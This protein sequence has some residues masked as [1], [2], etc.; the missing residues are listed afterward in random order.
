MD[1]EQRLI[2]SF[3]RESEKKIEM[4]AKI[5]EFE[6]YLKVVQPMNAFKMINETLHRC[7][8]GK[9]LRDCI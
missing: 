4:E 1:I 5:A 9:Q 6:K 7:L 2:E 8:K 3:K